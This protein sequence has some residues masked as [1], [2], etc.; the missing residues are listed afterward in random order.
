MAG[1]IIRLD[2]VGPVKRLLSHHPSKVENLWKLKSV[3][4]V[5]WSNVWWLVPW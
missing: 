5:V 2:K 4:A 3:V 1:K